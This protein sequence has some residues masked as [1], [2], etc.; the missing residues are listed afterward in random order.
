M[1]QEIRDTLNG[2]TQRRAR[3]NTAVGITAGVLIGA[4][5]GLL[6]APKSGKETRADIVEG[7][8]VGEETVKEVAHNI[9]EA[10][11]EKVSAIKTTFKKEMKK[12]AAAAEEAV[13]DE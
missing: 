10:A 2:T 12:E 9:A 5:A 11:K 6:F 3:R 4:I 8:K 7:V 1:F 13:K